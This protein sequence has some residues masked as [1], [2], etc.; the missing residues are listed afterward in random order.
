REKARADRNFERARDAVNKYFTLVSEDPDL[1]AR[2]LEPL[3]RKLLA[4]A[5]EYYAEFVRERGGEPALQAEFAEA[6]MRLG[7]I[8]EDIADKGKAVEE[9]EQALAL[10]RQ[11]VDAQPTVADH[12]ALLAR[13]HGNLGKLYA[14]LGRY[15]DAEAAYEKAVAIQ[16]Q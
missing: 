4:A 1:K 13:A 8:T 7:A 9:Y 14:A 16:E 11:L 5:R 6:H 15:P 12:Q 3:R 10:C 2:G